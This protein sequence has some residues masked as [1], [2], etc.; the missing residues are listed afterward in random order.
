MIV[1]ASDSYRAE[2]LEEVARDWLADAT[3]DD[4]IRALGKA[5][6]GAPVI[7]LDVLGRWCCRRGLF[8]AIP[9]DAVFLA[10]VARYPGARAVV[11]N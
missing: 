10:K 6:N 2:V 11:S 5:L 9:A 1:E 7:D 4:A 8:A 3:L